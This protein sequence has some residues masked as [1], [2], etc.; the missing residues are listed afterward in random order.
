[1]KASFCLVTLATFSSQKRIWNR[2][3]KGRRWFRLYFSLLW[4]PVR[5]ARPRPSENTRRFE[6]SRLHCCVFVIRCVKFW[7]FHSQTFGSAVCVKQAVPNMSCSAAVNLLVSCGHASVVLVPKKL[8]HWYVTSVGLLALWP[9]KAR[10]PPLV[11]LTS[12]DTKRSNWKGQTASRSLQI[13]GRV[14]SCSATRDVCLLSHSSW[15]NV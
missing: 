3:K 14:E 7:A 5:T 6:L 8:I 15:A 9:N 11:H 13:L 1:M 10:A 2:K 12:S 4:Q